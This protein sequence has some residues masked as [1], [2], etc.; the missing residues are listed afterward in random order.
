MHSVD[1]ADALLAVLHAIEHCGTRLEATRI[2]ADIREFAEV[3][4]SHDL[5]GER[6]ERLL[7][8]RL[9]FDEDLFIAHLVP[10]DRRDVK[11]ARKVGDNGVEHRLHA[12]VLER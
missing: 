10:R 7:V 5:E 8:I 2:D 1:L 12:L 3:R 6:R 11:R 9:T 4:I